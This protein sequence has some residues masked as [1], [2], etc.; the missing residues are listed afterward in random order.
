MRIKKLS[1]IFLTLFATL[2]GI[3]MVGFA[4]NLS[5]YQSIRENNFKIFL[6]NKVSE[7][8][9]KEF[10][11]ADK[12]LFNS[13][14][15]NK[16]IVENNILVS[17]NLRI[18]NTGAKIND[19]YIDKHEF[20]LTP[21]E[22]KK[23][24]N[25][26]ILEKGFYQKIKDIIELKSDIRI[27]SLYDQLNTQ[28][29]YP[30]NLLGNIET[31]V[32]KH[33]EIV[34][35]IQ[36]YRSELEQ[37]NTTYIFKINL[38]IIIILILF[39]II[40]VVLFQ[41]LKTRVYHSLTFIKKISEEALNDKF[42]ENINV[43]YDTLPEEIIQNLKKLFDKFQKTNKIIDLISKGKEKEIDESLLENSLLKT[44]FKNLISN[45]ISIKK[46][47]EER[48]KAEEEEKW[49]SEGVMQ[50]SEVFKLNNENVVLLAEEI[51]SQLVNYTK[52]A[53]GTIFIYDEDLDS[54]NLKLVA[55]YAYNRKRYIEDK[56]PLGRGLVGACAKE[57]H[58]IILKQ[59]PEDYYK[60]ET[61]IGQSA[62]KSVYIYPLL[63]ENNLLGVIELASF[64]ILGQKEVKYIEKV[65]SNI[66][67]SLSNA[68]NNLKTVRLLEKSRSQ[69]EEIEFRELKLQNIIEEHKEHKI[70]LENQKK[71]F[72]QYLKAINTAVAIISINHKGKIKNINENARNIL[73]LKGKSQNLI[74]LLDLKDD[75]PGTRLL[76]K[77]NLEMSNQGNLIRQESEYLTLD[78]KT[79]HVYEFWNPVKNI[80]NKIEEILILFID[81]TLQKQNE[82][83]LKEQAQEVKM[84]EAIM[85][86]NLEEMMVLQ[87]NWS[88][89]KKEFELEIE[90]KQKRIKELEKELN[91]KN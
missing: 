42:R 91:N 24:N 6:L 60:I 72:E 15:S 85:K 7:Y 64:D 67:I 10:F 29:T 86:Q 71:E 3:I 14:I 36:E 79:V 19:L 18:L 51:I 87:Q 32:I 40:V 63:I 22:R 43:K 26:T 27:T 9:D 68:Q 47:E 62:P 30:N 21:E 28:I 70:Q 11:W 81:I 58:P 25:L 46:K 31:L 12:I 55:G 4:L 2:V 77:E 82:I 66:S 78:K 53:Q 23:L 41:M 45:L 83:L 5:Y 56:V 13:T 48:R 74:S 57:K 8:H 65:A 75:T 16:S 80:D 59:V 52:A 1:T 35:F 69:N 20:N 76:F 90:K 33:N 84:Q 37:Q 49:I 50:I 44:S 88:E 89:E 34:D 73:G 17:K 54:E 61:A 38:T 39:L